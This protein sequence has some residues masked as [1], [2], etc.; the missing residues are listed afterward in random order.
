[1]QYASQQPHSR[2]HASLIYTTN[3]SMPYTVNAIGELC[4]HSQAFKR[5]QTPNISDKNPLCTVDKDTFSLAQ[6]WTIT[7]VSGRM[8]TLLMTR[9]ESAILRFPEGCSS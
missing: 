8:K 5:F 9:P 7:A 1:M 6:A 3:Y 2:T 4:S